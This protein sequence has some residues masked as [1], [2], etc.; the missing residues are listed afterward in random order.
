MLNDFSLFLGNKGGSGGDHEA[1]SNEE[2]SAEHLQRR[3]LARD[4]TL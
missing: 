1:Q 3:P 2:R 4:K